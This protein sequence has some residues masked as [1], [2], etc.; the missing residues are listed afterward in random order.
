LTQERDR[1]AELSLNTDSFICEESN[2]KPYIL[3]VDDD[4]SVLRAVERDLRARFSNDYRVVAAESP[5]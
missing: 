2:E 3:A 1:R 5:E 4:S